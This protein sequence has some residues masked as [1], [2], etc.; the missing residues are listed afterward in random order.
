MLLGTMAMVRTV[1]GVVL[2]PLGG[3]AADK[4][5]KKTIIV[6]TDF[7]NGI[8]Y[9]ALAYLV[10][11]EQLTPPVLLLLVLV[12]PS[13]IPFSTPLLAPLSHC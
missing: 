9:A 3:V 13:V 10:Y 11:T 6:L 4:I 5:N 7:V 12:A 2:S 1:I 8:I